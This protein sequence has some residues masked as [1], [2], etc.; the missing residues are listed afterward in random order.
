MMLILSTAGLHKKIKRLFKNLII[1][2]TNSCII[3]FV[4]QSQITH[5]NLFPMPVLKQDGELKF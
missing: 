3:D 2:W 4:S 1:H 5:D